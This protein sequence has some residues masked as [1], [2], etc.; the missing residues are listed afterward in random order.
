[1]SSERGAGERPV[2]IEAA[3]NGITAKE[4][5]PHTPK[6]PQEIT[7]DALACLDAGAAI[8]HAHNA[9]I[10]WQGEQAAAAYVAAMG[11]VLEARPE[12]L[13]YPTLAAAP[14]IEGKMAHLP[15]VAA[16]VFALA[17]ATPAA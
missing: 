16:A 13:W 11:P 15:A 2:I 8:I 4:Q 10:T 3:I 17:V 5:N 6:E 9:D 1:M 12:T 7:A 14:T